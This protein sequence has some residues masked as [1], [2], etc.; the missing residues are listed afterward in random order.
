MSYLATITT[1]G[2]AKIANAIATDTP[3]NLTT[4]KIGD[5]NGNPTTPAETDTDLVRSVY[6]GTT[7][8]I[9]VDPADATRVICELIVPAEEGG[10][11]I[12]EI[13][14]F[15]DE[16][17]LIAIA[18]FPAVYK[19]L[20]SEGATLDLV[21]RLFLVV[22]NT[23]AI[24]LQIDTAVVV[25]TRQWVNDQLDL[26]IP[27]GTTDQILTKVS[28]A[29]GDYE[30]RNPE[31][32]NVIVNT[33][34]EEQTLVAS[35]TIVDLATCTTVGLSIYIEGIRLHPDDWTATTASRVTLATSY[36]AGSKILCVQNEPTGQA[37][38]LA[39]SQNLADVP[40][41]A[42]ARA[43]LE[44]LTSATYLNSLW[45]LMQ[46]RTYPVGE[47][48]MT[49]QNGNPSSILGF[50]TWERYAQGRVLTGFDEADASFNALDKT[51]GAKTHVLT[52]AEMPAHTHSNI[53]ALST[54][55]D[56]DTSGGTSSGVRRLTS[57]TGS[58]GGGQAHNN[59]QPYVTVF[60]WKRTA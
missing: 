27:G 38:F 51:G 59:L 57:Q 48:F 16:D 31:D 6:S 49:R 21:A 7:N 58:T 53:V 19:P 35:Q 56:F 40:N 14:V 50:G 15:D 46:Q 12:R 39:Q 36:A 2:L 3:L 44:L 13:G 60:M 11:T 33:I 25:A 8:Y 23:D 42:T 4:M 5:G 28:N 29:D 10:F 54:T 34:Q 22:S 32:V 9:N 18:Q 30:W 45:Q 43:N 55:N 41:K 17:D 37:A 24:T 47:I 1:L 20:P 26:L 52:E